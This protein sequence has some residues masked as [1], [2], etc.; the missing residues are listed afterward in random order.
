MSFFVL[1]LPRSRTA[2]LANFLT[3]D[4]NFCY[5]EGLDGCHT[6]EEYYNKVDGVKGDSGTG[7][8]LIDL[9]KDSPKVI[10]ENDVEKSITFAKEVYGIYDPKF[11]YFLKDKLDSVEGLRV[12][13]ED[14]NDSLE[15]I[16]T[17]LIGTPYDYERGELLRNM[18]IQTN[19]FYD[20]DFNA[21]RNLL[22]LG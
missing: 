4:G 22:C 1:G 7:L 5:H 21:M 2:W 14:I 8:M 18:N 17:H 3:Y 19:N 20:Y 12:N 15:Q 11:F 13:F 16:W 10:I 9:P 6:I